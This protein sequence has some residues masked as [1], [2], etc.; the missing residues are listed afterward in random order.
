[1]LHGAGYLPTVTTMEHMG[2]IPI[3]I[4]ITVPSGNLT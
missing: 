2:Y 3:I 1:M 4:P